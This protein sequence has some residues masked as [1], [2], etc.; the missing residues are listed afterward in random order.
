MR[1]SSDATV[2]M[3]RMRGVVDAAAVEVES[4]E[5]DHAAGEGAL[6]VDGEVLADDLVV[7]PGRCGYPLKQRDEPR[8]ELRKQGRYLGRRHARVLA[9]DQRIGDVLGV[10]RVARQPPAEVERSLEQGPDGGEV[11]GGPAPSPRPHMRQPHVP[12][13]TRRTRPG[14]A[15]RVR[16][17]GE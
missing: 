12:R 9:V 8:A 10:G 1:T 17:R 4:H 5:V 7:V 6:G 3:N 14:R 15:R 13:G 16:S 11:I 2:V